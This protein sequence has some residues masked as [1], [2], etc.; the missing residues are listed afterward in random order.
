MKA[1][2]HYSFATDSLTITLD[3]S[4]YISDIK[5]PYSTLSAPN[6]L[7]LLTAIPKAN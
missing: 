3:P 4:S 6:R 2:H 5:Q 7:T 1:Q